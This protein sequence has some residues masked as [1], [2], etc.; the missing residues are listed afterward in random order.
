MPP[1]GLQ[2]ELILETKQLT[3]LFQIGQPGV[4]IVAHWV[5]NPIGI[6]EDVCLIPGLPQ[7]VKDLVLLQ[8]AAQVTDV[9]QILHCCGCD[10]GLQL[11]L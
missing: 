5:K 2:I 9:A 8:A 7:L 4:P 6:Y 3:C 11:Q 1:R 10:I